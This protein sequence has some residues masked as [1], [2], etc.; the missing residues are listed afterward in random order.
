MAELKDVVQELIKGTESGELEWKISYTNHCWT[1]NQ[2]RGCRFGVY[3][4][5]SP[6]RLAIWWLEYS[7]TF[8]DNEVAPLVGLLESKFPMEHPT[9]DRALQVALECLAGNGS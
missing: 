2:H 8:D 5:G 9:P 4:G 3:P 6:P 7:Q 1:T